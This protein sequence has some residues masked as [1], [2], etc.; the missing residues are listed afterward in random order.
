MSLISN[1]NK[2]KV[3][4]VCS[5]GGCGSWMVVNF[6][7]KYG[8]SYH[9]HKRK[10]PA[11]I[12]KIWDKDEIIK[13]H[14]SRHTTSCKF[15]ETDNYQN[16][17]IFIY[18]KPL[19][20]L[21]C[22]NSHG[23]KHWKNIGV[24]SSTLSKIQRPHNPKNL[25]ECSEDLIKYEEFWDNYVFHKCNLPILCLNYHFLWDNLNILYD[26]CH[27]DKTDIKNFPKKRIPSYER[28]GDVILQDI[29]NIFTSLN[30]KID[31]YPNAFIIPGK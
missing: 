10:V 9:M 29:N 20:S 17:I 25:L 8:Y 24:D 19:F 6:L 2:E 21:S 26:F 4:Y 7:S 27:I 23:D 3:F 11:Y 14:E 31:I 18:S 28:R 22:R 13:E 12:D 16:Y 1:D 5:Y 15:P 30:N